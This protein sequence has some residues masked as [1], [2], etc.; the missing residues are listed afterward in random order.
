MLLPWVKTGF[1]FGNRAIDIK[2]FFHL[3]GVRPAHVFH[4]WVQT[5]SRRFFPAIKI[6][7]QRENNPPIV[8]F[9]SANI[10]KEN[11]A[12][13]PFQFT[14]IFFTDI[15]KRSGK[16]PKICQLVDLVFD[17]IYKRWS[18]NNNMASSFKNLV[19]TNGKA[20]KMND[21]PHPV[22]RFTKTSI[23]FDV[24]KL[25]LLQPS[26]WF[27]FNYLIPNISD[28]NTALTYLSP[29]SCPG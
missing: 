18:Y 9:I 11:V 21:F 26:V 22:R 8:H 12:C 16:N 27:G 28:I 6:I 24:Q 17:K 4:C 15:T 1:E 20:W 14:W 13:H 5:V 10:L 2:R 23:L 19:K 29:L 25:D 3:R 7:Q